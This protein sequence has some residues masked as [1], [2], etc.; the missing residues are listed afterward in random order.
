MWSPIGPTDAEPVTAI[1]ATDIRDSS[2]RTANSAGLNEGDERTHRSVVQVNTY[3]YIA[4]GASD[5]LREDL[6][7]IL[8]WRRVNFNARGGQLQW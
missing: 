6:T 5:A 4:V 3:I 8:Q 7:N 1:G 2:K